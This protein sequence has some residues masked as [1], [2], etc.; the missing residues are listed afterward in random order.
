MR[1]C[2]MRQRKRHRLLPVVS[3]QLTATL[4]VALVLAVLGLSA[5]LGFAAHNTADI[6][7]RQV[8][9][10]V[11][12]N[13]DATTAQLNAM[14]TLWVG[15]PKI[16]DVKY[17]SPDEVLQRWN[18]QMGTSGVDAELL[19]GVNPFLPEFEVNVSA[20][21]AHPDSV[22]QLAG[23]AA[24]ME[25]VRE[26]KVNTATAADLQHTVGSI[27]LVLAILGGVLLVIS[28]ALINNTI[29]LSIYSHRF[30]IH[31]MRLVGAT[32]AFIRRPFVNRAMICGVI[33]AAI[34]TLLTGAAGAWLHSADPSIAAL[35]GPLDA[36]WIVAGM[37]VAGICICAIAA[38]F[39]TN[40]YIRLNYDEMFH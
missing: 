1:F 38:I 35:I 26:V 29:R 10:V 12:M 24:A 15:S 17:A 14:K 22:S 2:K 6:L 20:A 13:E 18:S 30:V 28:F 4:S 9:F 21:C 3:S 39:A 40:R 16:S 31:T 33:A 34:A 36:A 8:G 7:R 27:M 5:A 37:F 23:Q 19:G 25:G 32:A 11:V